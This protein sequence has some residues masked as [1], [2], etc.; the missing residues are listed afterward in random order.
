MFIITSVN[1]KY[2]IVNYLKSAAIC[3]GSCLLCG[4]EFNDIVVVK[5]VVGR[6]KVLLWKTMKIGE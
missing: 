1:F 6:V 3:A 2:F 4:L 5:C